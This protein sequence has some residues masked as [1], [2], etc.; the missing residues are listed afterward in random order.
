MPWN[1]DAD[2]SKHK[3]GLSSKQAAQWR[4]IA[5]SVLKRCMDKGGDEKTCAASA[6]KQAN[7]VVNANSTYSVYKN[8]QTLDY[9][10]KIVVHQEKAHLVVPV[11]MMVEGVHNGSLG[12]IYHPI[13]ELAKYPESWNGIPVVVYH[14]EKDGE[15]VSANSPEVIDAM[16]V[17]RV[18][19]TSVDGKKL[20]AEVWFDEEKL[21]KVSTNTLNDV[22]DSRQIE[23][24]LG[25]YADYEVE[26][27]EWN[28]ETY[29]MIAYNHRP[30]H[31]AIL[32]DQIGACSCADGC[33]LGVNNMDINATVTGMEEKRKELGMSVAEFYAVPRDPPGDSKLPIFDAAHVRNAMARFNQTQGLSAEEKKSAKGKIKAKAKKFKIDITNFSELEVDEMV[34]ALNV[35]GFAV[36]QIGNNADEG[37]MEK[38]QAANDAL[39]KFDKQ[40]TGNSSNYEYN[41][42]EELYDDSMVFSKSTADGRKYFKQD[43]QVT[44]GAVELTGNP[45]EVHKK[46]D[47]V[48]NTTLTRSKFST[49]NKKEDKMPKGNDCPKCLEKINALIANEQ[50]KFVEADREWLLTQEET[51]LDKLN[52][53]VVE[54]IIEK[55]VEVNK[56]SAEDQAIL[57]FGKKQMK[58]RKEKMVKGIQ[59]NTEGVWE[60]ETLNAMS[61]EMLE[62]VF[63]SIKKEEP[64][65]VYFGES[66]FSANAS[67]EEPLYPAGVKIETK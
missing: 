1:T 42:L 33:G 27:G 34:E 61:E 59:D 44:S 66:G 20:K 12:P 56:L 6:I 47:Y 21:N 30:D 17:G 31:L 18:Y 67:K 28:G 22:N 57:A 63:K 40:S 52:P 55:V 3:S 16:T 62:K 15:P 65:P 25:M 13:E 32:P 23:V 11:V 14:P 36:N 58:E 51:T 37:Y 10:P 4:R 50:S 9:E 29:Q 39:R 7:G 26:E 5:N 49:N 2:V 60:V 53:E 8:K 46:V 54:K 48:V 19:N 38:I 41:Y 64:A 35:Y 45:V 43:Y 24:S